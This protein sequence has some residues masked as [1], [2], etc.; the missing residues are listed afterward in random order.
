MRKTFALGLLLLLPIFASAAGF[1]KQSLFLSKTPVQEG[2]T[3]LIHSVV[4]NDATIKFD[5]S[6]V[7]SDQVGSAS[8]GKDQSIKIGSV[9]VTI[10]AGGAN[11]VSVSW[12]PSAGSHTIT[13]ELTGK[14]NIVVEKQSATFSIAA[15]PSPVLSVGTSSAAAVESSQNIQNQI[16]SL[17]PT[18]AEVS[19][20]AFTVIDGLRST[21][22]DFIDSQLASTKAKLATTPK[23]GVV[24]GDSTTQD[25]TISNPW[26]NVWFVL[27]TLYIYLL[28]IL[29]FLIGNAGVFYPLLAILFLYFLWRTYKRFRRPAWER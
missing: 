6:V 23:T 21:A 28:T 12:K 7:F 20:P 22:A 25:P 4:A 16:G 3:V 24:S 5:G 15:K 29:R 8:G 17:S 13:A 14:D 19:K 10:A 18:A 26:S 27:Y 9:V 2:E 1:A 11:A